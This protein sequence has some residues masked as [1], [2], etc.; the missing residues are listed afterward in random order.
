[1]GIERW[2][3]T[4]DDNLVVLPSNQLNMSKL[5]DFQQHD[6]R[7]II[8]KVMDDMDCLVVM[9]NMLLNRKQQIN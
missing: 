2:S 3:Y 6:N 8:R 4:Q 9:A 7:Y 5:D 1:M